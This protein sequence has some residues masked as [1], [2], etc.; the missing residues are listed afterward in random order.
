MIESPPVIIYKIK[1]LLYIPV[2][3][4]QEAA[5]GRGS[6]LI[7]HF[8]MVFRSRTHLH[9]P[10]AIRACSHGPDSLSAGSRYSFLSMRYSAFHILS[11]SVWKCQVETGG[12]FRFPLFIYRFFHAEIPENGAS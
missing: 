2:Q 5:I 10:V 12:I 6:T 8:L 4:V 1:R 3:E 7:S 9:A 11:S